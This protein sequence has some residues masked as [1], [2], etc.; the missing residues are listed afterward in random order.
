MNPI[1]AP[2]M[3]STIDR[4]IISSQ[5]EVVDKIGEVNSTTTS[6]TF[7]TLV[8]YILTRLS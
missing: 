3:V 4:V 2:M 1:V 5:M 7:D 6:I 8:I